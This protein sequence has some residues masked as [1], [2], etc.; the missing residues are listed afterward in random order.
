MKC[1]LFF[2]LASAVYAQVGI[3]DHEDAIVPEATQEVAPMEFV[4]EEALL[5]ENE[6]AHAK[7]AAFLEKAGANACSKLSDA[8]AQEVKDNVK[9]QQAILDKIDKG[10]NCPKRGQA[11][12][13]TMKDKLK[14]AENASKDA[15]KKY[16]DALNVDVDFGKRKFN[17]LTEGNCNSFFNSAAYTSAKKKVADAKK[18]TQQAAGKVTQAQKDLK[19]A[20]AAAKSEVKTCQCDTF[21]AHQKALADANAKVKASNTKA[22]TEAAH[23]KCVLAGKSMSSCTVPPLPK[24]KATSVAAGVTGGACSAWEGQPQCKNARTDWQTKNTMKIT[25]TSGNNQWN[26]GCWM[27]AQ[28][29]GKREQDYQLNGVW[30]ATGSDPGYAMWGFEHLKT[31]ESGHYYPTI[32]YAAYCM[33]NTNLYIYEK[34]NAMGSYSQCPCRSSANLRLVMKKD[35]TVLYQMYRAN[36]QNYWTTC[37]TSTR[38]AKNVPYIIDNSLYSNTASLTQYLTVGKLSREAWKPAP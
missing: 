38:K 31:G 6:E 3:T 18:K 5:Q 4:D 16:N 30:S 9:A 21:K 12:V 20:E 24:V 29:P 27:K 33:K 13:N 19:A 23:L 14:A 25:R 8:T 26:A 36:N 22:W 34:G 35:G 11:A 17:S 2:A 15:T 32:D 28:I 10:A 37:Y 7:A 1:I